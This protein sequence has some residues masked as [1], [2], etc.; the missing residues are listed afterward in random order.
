MFRPMAIAVCS[1]LVGS[2]ILA[3]LREAY[4]RSLVRALRARPAVLAVAITAVV[5]A[6]GSVAFIGTE[7]MP[8]LDEGYTDRHPQAP[9]H[10]PDRVRERQPRIEKTVLA[11]RGSERV[12]KLGRP[13]FAKD[14]QSYVRLHAGYYLLQPHRHRL[15]EGCRHQP[16]TA[17]AA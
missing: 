8:K 4:R 9:G 17:E 3:L 1:S 5:V 16:H 6:V 14:L 12:T 13:D 7:F 11:S 15:D 10:R 2:L